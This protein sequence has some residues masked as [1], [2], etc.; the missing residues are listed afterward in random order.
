MAFKSWSSKSATT[1]LESKLATAEKNS[2]VQELHD[3]VGR[4][5]LPVFAWVPADI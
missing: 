1:F 4:Y 5:R 2:H 3:F